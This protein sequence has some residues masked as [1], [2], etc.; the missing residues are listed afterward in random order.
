MRKI[1]FSLVFV[2]FL[3]CN[4]SFADLTFD[5]G[6]LGTFAG[7]TGAN[8]STEY[9]MTGFSLSAIHEADSGNSSAQSIYDFSSDLIGDQWAIF[10]FDFSHTRDGESYSYARSTGFVNFSLSAETNYLFSGSNQLSGPPFNKI[11]IVIADS[12]WTT[13]YVDISLYATTDDELLDL[14]TVT[15]TLP[16]GSYAFLYDYWLESDPMGT[17]DVASATGTLTFQLGDPAIVPVPGA[18]LLGLFGLGAVG[19]KLRKFA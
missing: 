12:G 15:D 8:D 5:G 6:Y 1:F 4:I 11:W 18:V 10:D 9:T 2:I 3:S 7:D 13:R 14:G 17:T 19:V 16:A